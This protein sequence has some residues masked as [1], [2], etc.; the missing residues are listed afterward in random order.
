M[1]TP[2]LA[3][4]MTN[5]KLR[6]A[7]LQFAQTQH[8]EENFLFYMDVEAYRRLVT[9][10]DLIHHSRQIVE[11]FLNFSSFL[12]YATSFWIS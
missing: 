9:P 5:H 1:A 4:V 10:R 2:T 8:A 3:D 12:L 7:F 11:V 6:E